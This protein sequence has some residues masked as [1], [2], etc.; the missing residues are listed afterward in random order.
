MREAIRYT[1]DY[2][3]MI[4]KILLGHAVEMQ[5]PAAIGLPGHNDTLPVFSQDMAK[6]KSLMGRIGCDH[7]DH[8]GNT[9][10]KPG[11]K[12]VAWWAN[13]S[14]L[15][16][17]RSASILKFTRSPGNRSGRASSQDKSQTPDLTANGW[18]PDYADVQDYLYPMYHSSQWPP[19]RLNIGFYKNETVDKLLDQALAEND[20]TLR[21]GLY[22]QAQELI[23]NDV[24]SLDLYQK[25]M[26]IMMHD[27][28]KGFVYNPIYTEAFNI[29][30][31]RI[32]K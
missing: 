32:S 6:A 30:D 31:M 8:P 21:N 2:K 20:P 18:W 19:A 27:W 12:T 28:V 9:Q 15:T 26:T 23:V 5:G 25:T 10:T 29:Y 13:C 17:R 4:D 1:L 11:R 3:S 14:I 24:A 7:P 16:W 22:E